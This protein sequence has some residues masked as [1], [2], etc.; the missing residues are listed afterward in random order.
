ME[1]LQKKKVIVENDIFNRKNSDSIP[2]IYFTAAKV[3]Q[4]RLLANNRREKQEKKN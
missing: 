2:G 1:I 3:A 4:C